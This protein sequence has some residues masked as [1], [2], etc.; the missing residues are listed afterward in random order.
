MSGSYT[1]FMFYVDIS[2]ISLQSVHILRDVL[3]S[4]AYMFEQSLPMLVIYIYVGH[5][6]C[7]A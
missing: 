4:R 6:H 3:M 1:A 5:I 7:G 2:I